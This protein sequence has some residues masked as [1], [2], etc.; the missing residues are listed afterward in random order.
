MDYE[1]SPEFA[2]HSSG[3]DESDDESDEDVPDEKVGATSEPKRARPDASASSA[4]S[5]SGRVFK[6]ARA[7]PG[8]TNAASKQR[9]AK[10][11]GK[12][13]TF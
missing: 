3:E 10:K 9:V 12:L 7:T 6:K 2:F 4:A 11:R 1:I 8:A 13:V 5:D